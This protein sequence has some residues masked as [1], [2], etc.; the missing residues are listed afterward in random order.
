MSDLQQLQAYFN[1][2]F[3]QQ[4]NQSASNVHT[5]TVLLVIFVAV[6][7]V[8]YVLLALWVYCAVIRARKSPT[9]DSSREVEEPA[10]WG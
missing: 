3:Q 1:A 10:T 6:F 4:I 7:A 8:L 5:A 9:P 2:S